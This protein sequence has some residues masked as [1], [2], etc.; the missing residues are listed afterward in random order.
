ML[1]FRTDNSVF[2]LPKKN[3]EEVH[4]LH[5]RVIEIS[6][7]SFV[8]LEQFYKLLLI[9]VVLRACS[10]RHKTAELN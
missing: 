10:L 7:M 6:S 5:R 4:Q 3:I 8:H 2:S 1:K 9:K